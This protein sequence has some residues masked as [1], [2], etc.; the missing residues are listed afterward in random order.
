MA[1]ST[2]SAADVAGDVAKSGGGGFFGKVGGF[3]SG[4]TKKAGNLLGKLN[5]MTYLKKLFTDKGSLK[6]ILGKIPKIGSIINLAMTAYELYSKG[7]SA[8]DMKAQGASYQDIGKSVLMSV[9]D[10]GGTLLGGIAGTFLSPGIGNMIGGTLGGMAGS[11]LA[12]FL[13]DNID[14][15]GLGKGVVDIFGSGGGQPKKMAAGGI[16]TKATNIVAGE[17][18]AEAIIP[19]TGARGPSLLNKVAQVGG[20]GGAELVAEMRAVKAVLQQILHKEGD[21]TLDG[22]KVGTDLNIATRKLQ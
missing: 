18:G 14:V 16:V 12:G 5:P 13:A 4:I 22:V 10:L 3:F 8:A 21:I 7:E 11:K 17:A 2:S 6:K 20:G 15:S 9:G 19:L 1:A